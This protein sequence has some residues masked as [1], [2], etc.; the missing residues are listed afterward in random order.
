MPVID[1]SI[2][3]LERLIGETEDKIVKALEHIKGEVEAREGDRMKIEITH[4]RPDHFS[5]EGLAR[6]LKGILGIEIGLPKVEI[7]EGPVE[8]KYIGT[9]E[10][11]PYAVMAVVRGLR[12]DDEA[13]VQMIQLQEKLHDT[14]GRDRRKIAIGFYDLSKL[15]P[16]I[17]YKRV[18][19]EDEYVPLGLDKPVKIKE[20]YEITDKGRRYSALINRERPPALVDSDGKIMV[21]IPVLGSEC[22]KVTPSTRD[23]LIDVTGPQLEPLLKILAILS[24]SLA[25]RSQNK[26]IELVRINGMYPTRFEGRAFEVKKEA[27]EE[28]LGVKFTS[29][30][31][32]AL[33]RRAR[34]DVQDGRVLVAPYRINV[35]SWVDIAEDIAIMKGYNN[36]PREPPPII[37]AGRKHRVEIASEDAR[38]ALSVL[39]FQEVM[40]GVLT[41]SALFEAFGLTYPKVKNPV[42]ER[43]DA[44]RASILPELLLVAAALRRPKFKLFEVGDVVVNGLTRRAVAVAMGGEGITITDGISAIN[45]LCLA[46]GVSCRVENWRAPWCIEGRCAKID[47]GVSGYVG[48]VKPEILV[49]FGVFTPL[50]LGELF[51]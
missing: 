27:V 32:V 12:L 21:V 50:V 18:S 29:D 43:L 15:K 19:Q 40:N 33:L 26:K 4:D 17:F 14:Y 7:V 30:E 2:W 38:R 41:H 49:G 42:S 47:G 9:I 5:A 31:Y 44:V 36:L 22:C 28:V 6:T 39:G 24:Y 34:H 11:R 48:E 51:L 23:V 1:V 10:E 20:M 25:E 45:A 37:T 3:D 16:P 46:L 8:L 35:L 13:I